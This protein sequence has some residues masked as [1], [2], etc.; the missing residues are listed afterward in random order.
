MFTGLYLYQVT[1][2][3]EACCNLFTCEAPLVSPWPTMINKQLAVVYCQVLYTVLYIHVLWVGNSH[4]V[5]CIGFTRGVLGGYILCG[6]IIVLFLCLA[7]L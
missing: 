2:K 6:H 5:F 7:T 4:A 1:N 3:S